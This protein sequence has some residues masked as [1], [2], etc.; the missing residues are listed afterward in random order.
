MSP[1]E[2]SCLDWD[3]NCTFL[4]DRYSVY[5]ITR[6]P[7]KDLSLFHWYCLSSRPASSLALGSRRACLFCFRALQGAGVAN[8]QGG[9]ASCI[10]I[11]SF[12]QAFKLASH[13][14]PG[15]LTHLWVAGV[16]MDSTSAQGVLSLNSLFP[17]LKHHFEASRSK[18][19]ISTVW[20]ENLCLSKHL[21]L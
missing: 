1:Q 18:L 7:G 16:N 9:C 15:L 6:W 19:F 13:L 20:P 10:P 11:G 2:W 3:V 12:A 21:T 17:G 5:Q 8:S 4:P 14:A